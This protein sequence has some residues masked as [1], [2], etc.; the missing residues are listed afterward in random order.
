MAAAL[1]ALFVA[2]TLFVLVAH[3]RSPGGR[4]DAEAGWLAFDVAFGLAALAMVLARVEDA[5][6][7]VL[8]I[9]VVRRLVEMRSRRRDEPTVE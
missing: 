8:G 1:L 6:L 5:L 2:I 9:F 7:I 3:L 4:T